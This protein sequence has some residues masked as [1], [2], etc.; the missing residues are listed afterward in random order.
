MNWSLCGTHLCLWKLEMSVYVGR[1]LPRTG[2]QD[3]EGVKEHQ[4]MEPWEGLGAASTIV[5][6]LPSPNLVF[7]SPFSPHSGDLGGAGFPPPLVLPETLSSSFYLG[8]LMPNG[9]SGQGHPAD[10]G[11][12]HYLPPQAENSSGSSREDMGNIST[13]YALHTNL[14]LQ[15]ELQPRSQ[16]CAPLL[17]CN[18]YH[19]QTSMYSWDL[20]RNRTCSLPVYILGLFLS[21][22]DV[23]TRPSLLCA[24]L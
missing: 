14:A 12:Q 23:P 24:P 8:F 13:T 1:N 17:F 10:Q 4:R 16:P 15:A 2:S 5:T 6:P 7:S 21:R 20:L 19:T 11:C 18:F 3:Q 22:G 9:A